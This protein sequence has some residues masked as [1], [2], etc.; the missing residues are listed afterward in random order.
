[1]LGRP[2]I[3]F[4][5]LVALIVSACSSTPEWARYDDGSPIRADEEHEATLVLAALTSDPS[6]LALIQLHRGHDLC[7]VCTLEG[8]LDAEVSGLSA[9]LAEPQPPWAVERAQGRLNLIRQYRAEYPFDGARCPPPPCYEEPEA[10]AQQ[11]VE[12]DVE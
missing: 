10:A 1:M 4:F 3:G 9:F 6:L 5:A 12:P 8:Q 2:S 7:V 11:G